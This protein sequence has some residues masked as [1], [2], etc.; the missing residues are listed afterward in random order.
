GIRL[1]IFGHNLFERVPS[2]FAPLD[3]VQVT[4]DYIIGPGDELVVRAW[5]QINVDVRRVVDR[6]GAIYIPKVGVFN[7]AGVRYE[8]M[9]SY[10]N[11]EM[12]RILQHFQLNV[13]M[14]R[15][16]SIDVFVVGQ[17]RRPG[18]YTI[19]SLSSLIDALFASGGPS[20]RGSMRR[21]QV[22]RDGKIVT[23]FDLYDLMVMG[24]KSKDVKLMPGDVIYVPPVGPLVA[25]A[26]SVNIPGVYE[27]RDNAAMGEVIGY[28]GGLSNT[29]AG[30]HAVVERIDSQHVRKAEEFSLDE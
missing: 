17:V 9:D 4:P 3:R 29:A 10:L 12:G 13:T 2:T 23:T 22:K 26:G 6:S 16:R 21:I 11:A 24:D 1:D 5:G 30:E 25:L 8:Q 20:K 18:T 7:V 27:L 19:S 28:A 15:L 14:G